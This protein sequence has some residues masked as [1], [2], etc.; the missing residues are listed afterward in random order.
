MMVEAAAAP[1]DRE[2]PGPAEVAGRR[3]KIAP[4][5]EAINRDAVFKLVWRPACRLGVPLPSDLTSGAGRDIY[6][7]Q[8]ASPFQRSAADPDGDPGANLP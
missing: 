1:G 3:W 7:Q 2:S 5:G 8:Q 4:P 6:L